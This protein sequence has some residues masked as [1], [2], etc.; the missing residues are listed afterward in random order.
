M[1]TSASISLA[2]AFAVLLGIAGMIVYHKDDAIATPSM[3]VLS[4]TPTIPVTPTPQ[5]E[6][7]VLTWT[8]YHNDKYNFTLNT[9]DGWHQQEY[10]L[11]SGVF[12]VAF[13]P[14]QLP[15]P[16]CTYNHNGYF[17]IKIYTN[18]TDPLAYKDFTTRMQNVG[19][20]NDFLAIRLDGKPGVLFA[21]TIAAENNGLVYELA[22]DTHDGKD[23]IQNSKLFQKAANS[24]VF[25]NLIFTN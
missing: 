6:P 8:S 10:K 16:T 23:T 24:F 15:C 18:Q 14:D 25:T 22:L 13:S 11:D 20:S 12:L 2:L 1:K 4:P 19:K 9:P 17:S 21:N 3:L 7:L 5:D